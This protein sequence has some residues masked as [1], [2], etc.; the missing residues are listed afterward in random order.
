MDNDTHKVYTKCTTR[1][2]VHI[3]KYIEANTYGSID[4]FAK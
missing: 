4:I 1:D 2:G 3:D